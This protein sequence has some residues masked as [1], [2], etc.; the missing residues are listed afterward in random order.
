[1]SHTS[2]YPEPLEDDVNR[3]FLQAWRE[4]RLALPHCTSCDRTFYYPRHA[5]PHCW[6]VDF[7][8]HDMSGRAEIVSFSLVYRPN[9]ESFN[10]EVPIVLAEV[11]LAEQDITMIARVVCDDAS[12]VYSGMAIKL[13]GGSVVDKYPL[14]T[15]E[16]A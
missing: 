5:C 7:D 12:L 11:K 8:W 4:G 3:P 1:M 2:T 13:L 6:G 9:H 10:E 15:F 14:P 16:P